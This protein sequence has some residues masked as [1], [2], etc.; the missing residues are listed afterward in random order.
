MWE[1]LRKGAL[2]CM[3]FSCGSLAFLSDSSGEQQGGRGW[4]SSLQ[5]RLHSGLWPAVCSRGCR[6]VPEHRPLQRDWTPKRTL[7]N[8]QVHSAEVSPLTCTVA[9]ASPLPKGPPA[10]AGQ[11]HPEFGAAD[12]PG[13]SRGGAAMFSASYSFRK[14]FP[15]G[16]LT[17]S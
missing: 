9:T 10:R 11:R 16:D 8:T 5:G 2:A 7:Y 17:A 3:F 15:C 12:D 4:L 1:L 14:A 6:R 13:T